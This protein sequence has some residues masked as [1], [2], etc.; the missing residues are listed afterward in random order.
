LLLLGVVGMPAHAAC[1]GG[2]S[3]RIV[4]KGAAVTK[5][6][7]LTLKNLEAYAPAQENVTYFT[8]SGA[9]TNAF[10]GALLWDV[11]NSPPIGPI[12]FSSTP[13]NDILH[14][15][16]IVTGTDCYASVFGVGE[17]A[18]SF[19]DSQIILAYA[20]NGAS[21]GDDGFAQLV[22]P[23]DKYGGRFVFNIATIEVKDAGK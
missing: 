10:T 9:V 18:P 17:I 5:S 19:G 14:K 20:A 12:V 21:L 22:A 4:V 6:A 2:V 1:S 23:G 7:V 8:M 3:S 16:I 11:L 13:K 15:I